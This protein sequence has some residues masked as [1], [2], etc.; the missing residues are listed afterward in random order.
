MHG[1]ASWRGRVQATE[2]TCSAAW[3]SS[4]ATCASGW[5]RRPRGWTAVR[6]RRF[7]STDELSF[8]CRSETHICVVRKVPRVTE[9]AATGRRRRAGVAHRAPADSHATDHSI[10]RPKR[11]R[12]APNPV[13]RRPREP[14]F[15]RTLAYAL[16]PPQ[17]PSHAHECL[18]D[19]EACLKYPRCY[20]LSRGWTCLRRLAYTLPAPCLCRHLPTSSTPGTRTV[21]ASVAAR[22]WPCAAPAPDTMP[23]TRMANPM[24]SSTCHRR[25]ASL[26]HASWRMVSCQ[27]NRVVMIHLRSS[28]PPLS[29]VPLCRW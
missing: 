17:I 6:A 18:R 1:G 26:L 11:K 3:S 19:S 14:T 10:T 4:A 2:T 22:N 13:G 7:C 21:T 8:S 29:D 25:A 15:V 16:K 12:T 5:R 24:R 23:S 28:F 27:A 20:S 9:L